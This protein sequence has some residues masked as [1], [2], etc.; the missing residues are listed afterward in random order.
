MARASSSL[1]VASDSVVAVATLVAGAVHESGEPWTSVLPRSPFGGHKAVSK[2]GVD[3]FREER[4]KPSDRWHAVTTV[5]AGP[6]DVVGAAVVAA[7][8]FAATVRAS[9]TVVGRAVMIQINHG[10]L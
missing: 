8:V 2:T 10:W 6:T 9:A 7:L 5:V 4:E 3:Q 1:V